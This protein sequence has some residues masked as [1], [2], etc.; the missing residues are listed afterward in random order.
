MWA[1]H[2]EFVPTVSRIWQTKIRG[3]AMYS[4]YTKLKLLKNELK[5]LNKRYYSNISEQ[6]KNCI[7][8]YNNL[9]DC[10]LSFY[11]Q[12]A[13]ILWSVQ[14]DRCTS[15]FHSVIKS[16]R[17]Q[18]RILMLYN[19]AGEK[20]SDEEK[21]T[22][23]FITFYKNL[24]GTSS[25]TALVDRN[26]PCLSE[27]QARI[28]SNPVNS[29]EIKEAVFS[30]SDIKAPGPDGYGISFYKSA[31]G[32]VGD[33]I[34]LAIKDFFKTGK[35]LGEIN[36][37]AITLIPKVQ[38]PRNPSDFRPI[39]CC[40]CLY[41][42][43]SKILANRIRSVIGSLVNEAQNAFVKGRQISS[44]ILLAHE[45]A[46]NYNRK[47]ISPRAMLNIDIKKAFDTINWGFLKEM[48]IGL[49]FPDA[50]I[51]WIMACIT[52]PKYSIAFNGAL[53][54]Y[55]KGERGLRQ[56][57]GL[58]ANLN[59]C[60]IFYGGIDDSVKASI[61]N[62]LGFS[63]GTMPIRY[64]GV[65]LIC[66]RLSY[67]DCAPRL[68][69]IPDQ[70]QSCSHRKLSYA[71]RLQIIKSSI[72]G[73]Q[74]FW[75]SNYI[76]PARVLK[77]VDELC[78][79]FLWGKYDQS[80]K[81]F[82]LVAWERVCLDKKKGGLGIF[83]ATIWNLASA[84]QAKRGDSW[85]CK[86]LLKARDKAVELSGSIDNLKHII[87]SS[88]NSSKIKIAEIYRALSPA[89]NLV[90]WL[91]RK[92]IVNA[93][94]CKM[95][96]GACLESRDH[97]FFECS[98]SKEVWYQIMDWLQFKWRSCSWNSLLNW[99][100][101]KL[102][103]KGIKQNIK[104]SAMSATIYH[105]WCERNRRIFQLKIQ[106]GES[107]VKRIKV[108]ILTICLNSPNI[109]GDMADWISCGTVV[110]GVLLVFLKAW[111]KF[112]EGSTKSSRYCYWDAGQS[113]K[114]K[115]CTVFLGLDL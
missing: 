45:L 17:D 35:L 33:E 14:G 113:D 56:V 25:V 40:N 79:N 27:A 78:R 71:G 115:L 3:Y 50:Y 106:S 46:K 107:L 88:S 49:G 82:P 91:L 57:S 111:S 22:S 70:F 1:K 59:K 26:G 66:K 32:I 21:I 55:F 15:Y 37:T 89:A 29:E 23:E 54:G 96:A 74:V 73:I 77:K 60:S 28:L 102:I 6:E 51:G 108:D 83:S 104:R 47:H 44:N 85:M 63:E 53:H 90:P 65:P 86:Q 52:S 68:N 24:M 93:N 94:Q 75:T 11:Q 98:F 100:C 110:L 105:L 81:V 19:S 39:A 20:L 42:I 18:N 13:R 36:S 109:A 58:S 84:V 48:L 64:L 10:E 31:W 41:K 114:L 76:L 103:K 69:R 2:S 16:K 72:L 62:S 61:F 43:I 80:V 87:N 5:D 38:C 67:T 7:T 4:V 99:Y 101:T 12:K 112:G 8:S 30:M 95:C 9:L 34:T 92:G 97:L